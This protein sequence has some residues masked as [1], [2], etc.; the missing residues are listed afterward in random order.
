M[1][2]IPVKI[3]IKEEGAKKTEGAIDDLAGDSGGGGVEGLTSAFEGLTAGGAGGPVGI[4]LAAVGV[5]F[6]VAVGAAAA[7]LEVAIPLIID[8]GNELERQ[9]GIINR[10]RGSIELASEAIG[11]M[12]SNIDLMIA[13][14]RLLQAGL[15]LTDESF[16]AIAEVAA[17][18]AA[19]I[20][21]DVVGA[22]QMLGEALRTVSAEGLAPFGVILDT[23][24]S[25]LEQQNDALRQ[26]RERAAELETGAD[27]LGGSIRQLSVAFENIKTDI[28][29]VINETSELVTLFNALGDEAITLANVLGADLQEGFSIGIRA[30]AAFV[31]ILEQGIDRLTI[32][33]R[34]YRNAQQAFQ[35]GDFTGGLDAM[36]G[37][38]EG[39]REF[40]IEEFTA[41][42]R[43]IEASLARTRAD[44]GAGAPEEDIIAAPPAV[45]GPST[46]EVDAISAAEQS[47]L[48]FMEQ[49]ADLTEEATFVRQNM[50]EADR[51][52]AENTRR[53]QEEVLERQREINEAA[54][55][56]REIRN[57]VNASIRETVGDFTQMSIAQEDMNRLL[58]LSRLRTK[59]W[60]AT[61][62]EVNK[63]FDTLKPLLQEAVGILIK[64]GDDMG[65]AFVRALDAFLMNFAIQEG[66]ESAKEFVLA[67]ASAASLD[68]PGAALHA[69][70]GAGHLALAVAAG[71]ASAA[72]P[73][74]S[75]GAGGAAGQPREPDRGIGAEGPGQLIIN[76]QGQALLTEAEIGRSVR[77]ALE[78]ENRRF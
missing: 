55:E 27:T 59:A 33:V 49:F 63:G 16:A 45:R 17:D 10:S 32:M 47:T 72:I 68:V 66:F 31:A 4:A 29:D 3:K 6:V 14:N 42:V 35:S 23:N 20:G 57:D 43:E 7:A 58:F 75:G 73:S 13:R 38:L 61:V 36:A 12:V 60:Q 5:G 74:P 50:Q 54:R 44:R 15:D 37:V 8:F 28:F 52:A 40:D 62:S 21:E 53:E 46:A 76:I 56:E 19:G 70:A 69:A 2:E 11:G 64:G 18:A 71:G 77:K 25:R 26:M 9:G 51:I 65:E 48:V 34:A 24:L 41:R 78:A 30:G 22:M 1:V 39:F 67:I